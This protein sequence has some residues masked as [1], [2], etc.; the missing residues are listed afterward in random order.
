M[1]CFDIVPNHA[2]E[3]YR[4]AFFTY[5]INFIGREECLRIRLDRIH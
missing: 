2:V 4:V 5:Y 3:C 1:S